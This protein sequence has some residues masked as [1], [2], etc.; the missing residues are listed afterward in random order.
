VNDWLALILL[1]LVG[2]GIVALL[3]WLIIETEGVYLGQRVVTLLYDYYAGRYEDVKRFRAN[4]E[5][6]YLSQPL[7]Q[8]IAPL[9]TPLVLDVATGTG[10]LPWALLQNGLFRGL[11]IGVDLSRHMLAIADAKTDTERVRFARCPAEKLPFA[12]ASFDVV[13][14]LEALEFM[15]DPRKALGEMARV[16]KPNGVLL[17]TNRLTGHWLK[18]RKWTAGECMVILESC[19]FTSIEFERW[20]ADYDRVWARRV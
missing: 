8:E 19:G 10:R 15:S 13:T 14:C 18:G 20:Q 17:T 11:V 2:F 16:L 9:Q 1:V 12:D 4:Y 7:M 3:Y 6:Q 5:H